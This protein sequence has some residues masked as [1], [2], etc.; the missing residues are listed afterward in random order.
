MPDNADSQGGL[1]KEDLDALQRQATREDVDRALADMARDTIE[2][3]AGDGSDG[4]D[5]IQFVSTDPGAIE[6]E[7]EQT[8]PSGRMTPESVANFETFPLA[9]DAP[10]D[11]PP[12]GGFLDQ[13]SGPMSIDTVR[14][15]ETFRDSDGNPIETDRSRILDMQFGGDTPPPA[16]PPAPAPRMTDIEESIASD[17]FLA[18]GPMTETRAMPPSDMG[19]PMRSIDDAPNFETFPKLPDDY[20][21]KPEP[22]DEGIEVMQAPGV[23]GIPRSMFAVG[24]GVVLMGLALVALLTRGGSTPP[25]STTAPQAPVATQAAS[26]ASLVNHA[27]CTARAVTAAE[28]AAIPSDQRWSVSVYCIGGH[29]Y[30][31]A[32]FKVVS[33]AECQ[34]E[35]NVIGPG[36]FYTTISGGP[37]FAIDDESTLPNPGA[38]ACGFLT[39]REVLTANEWKDRLVDGWFPAPTARWRAWEARSGVKGPN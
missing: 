17:A 35:P 21:P 23:G 1:R 29:W 32:Q 18:D 27:P 2:R 34:Y 20:D 26:A 39:F 22:Q 15:F 19:R 4:A 5:P 30:P 33:S 31:T 37:A 36:S 3:Q 38:K 7:L 9:P 28:A 10:G 8:S 6:R 11:A 24:A 13:P 14:N 12:S 16:T 25:A